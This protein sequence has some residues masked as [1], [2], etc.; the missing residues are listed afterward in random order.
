MTS[1]LVGVVFLIFAMLQKKL[2]SLGNE[3]KKSQEAGSYIERYGI[4]ILGMIF[5]LIGVTGL[6]LGVKPEISR[7]E[8]ILLFLMVFVL[9]RHARIIN[10]ASLTDE[11]KEFI[12]KNNVNYIDMYR[13]AM[14]AGVFPKTGECALLI[15][16]LQ[17]IGVFILIGYL[18]I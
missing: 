6:A 5:L 2:H 8:C 12:N 1:T 11:G 4:M 15:N 13:I 3:I 16:I 10:Y 9:I 7:K 14:L 17:I 18:T